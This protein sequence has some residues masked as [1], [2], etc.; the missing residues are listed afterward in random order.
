MSDIS[1]C[2]LDF[3]HGLSLISLG[4]TKDG[5]KL[6]N[7]RV[8]IPN[9]LHVEKSEF[10]I[11]R[12]VNLSEAKGKKVLVLREQGIGDQLWLLGSLKKFQETADCS[13]ALDVEPRLH[14]LMLR[15]FSH[16]EILNY[17]HGIDTKA[18]YWIAYGDLPSLLNFSQ[19]S[20]GLSAPYLVVDENL[21]SY[22]DSKLPKDKLRIGLAWRSGNM[23]ARRVQYYTELSDWSDLLMMN[24]V[25]FICLQYFVVFLFE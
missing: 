20:H 22:W 7:Q 8:E 4:K 14:S 2:Q 25:C 24:D 23:D 15:S 9:V 5:W 1:K 19:D 13:I 16:F 6:W 10:K 12:L 18:D 3:V 17:R 21:S 11:P